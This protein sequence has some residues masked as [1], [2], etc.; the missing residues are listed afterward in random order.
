MFLPAFLSN[1]YRQKVGKNLLA[2]IMISH[3]CYI[4]HSKMATFLQTPLYLAFSLFFSFVYSALQLSAQVQIYPVAPKTTDNRIDTALQDHY[5]FVNRSVT[6]LNRLVIFFPGTG[7]EPRNYRVFPTVAANLGFHAIGLMYPNDE[8]VNGRC[9][10]LSADLD[11]YGAIRGE[12]LDGINRTDKAVVSL[13]NS[14]ENRCVKLLQYLHRQYPQDNWAQYLERTAT[15]DTVPRWGNIIVAGH[16]QGGGYAG[17]IAV[18]KRVARC[19]MFGAMDYNVPAR[20]MANWMTGAKATP[21]GEFFAMGHIRD[22]LVN[23]ETL[24]G[25][26]WTAYG[27]PAAGAIVNADSVRLPIPQT[28]SFSTNRESPVLGSLVVVAPRHNVPVVDVNTPLE[29]GRYVFQP[30]WEYMLTAP[31][32]TTSIHEPLE[33]QAFS[34]SPNPASNLLI[35]QGAEGAAEL[36]L[37]NMLGQPLLQ[38]SVATFPATIDVS[39]LPSGCYVLTVQTRAGERFTRQVRVMR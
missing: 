33:E 39:S 10:A 18:T 31:T 21:Q 38:Q 14:I 37:L 6:T 4:L 22:E 12:T 23:Y 24:S 32:L 34:I 29:T 36:V 9:G 19:I 20:R 5:A 28:R 30:V 8:T 2:K 27:I 13:A 11:C 25:M 35:V 15:G 1:F 7:A 16:S 3:L 17:Y 26:A